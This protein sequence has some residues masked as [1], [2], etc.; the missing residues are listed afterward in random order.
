MRHV[1]RKLKLTADHDH[2]DN[3]ET[4]PER[5]VELATDLTHGNKVEYH[6]VDDVPEES[7][8]PVEKKQPCAPSVGSAPYDSKLRREGK[9]VVV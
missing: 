6:Q 2:L 9:G 1:S 7:Q 5:R 8:V 4:L 3:E